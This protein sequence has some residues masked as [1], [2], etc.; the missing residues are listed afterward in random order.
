MYQWAK[1]T[2][3]EV[4]MLLN[5][6]Q[7]PHLKATPKPTLAELYRLSITPR[8][9]FMPA[10]LTL[11]MREGVLIA[12][13]LNGCIV[14]LRDYPLAS[15]KRL[16]E[17]WDALDYKDYVEYYRSVSPQQNRWWFMDL[18]QWYIPPFEKALQEKFQPQLEQYT[19]GPLWYGIYLMEHLSEAQRKELLEKG[20]LQ[21]DLMGLPEA[22]RRELAELIRVGFCAYS[23]GLSAG[24]W[25]PRW[26]LVNREYPREESE[27]GHLFLGNRPLITLRAERVSVGGDKAR[28]RLRFAPN[29][30]SAIDE[31]FAFDTF[32]TPY[33]RWLFEIRRSAD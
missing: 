6:A 23:T 33:N 11:Q 13:V 32:E 3:N 9:R 26:L 14:R 25:H 16:Y 18:W 24:K 19:F 31:Y 30:S 15:L 4:L 20:E 28:L 29:P 12:D 2:G 5:P 27:E 1:Q 21:V 10:W 22:M 17:H 8:E 7:D